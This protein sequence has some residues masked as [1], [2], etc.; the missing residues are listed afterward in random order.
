MNAHRE[1]AHSVGKWGY[2]TLNLHPSNLALASPQ[3]HQY[4]L[5]IFQTES[6][7]Y[8]QEIKR[9]LF[10]RNHN[11]LSPSGETG[12]PKNRPLT[13]RNILSEQFSLSTEITHLGFSF[14][15]QRAGSFGVN[16]RSN[17]YFETDFNDFA[18]EVLFQGDGFANYIDTVVR[19][20]MDNIENGKVNEKK[21]FELLEDSYLKIN[22][23]HEVNLGYARQVHHKGRHTVLGGVKLGY[24][25]GHADMALRFN[26]G[27]IRGYVS[28]IPYLRQDLGAIN[29]PDD[30]GSRSRTGHG[31]NF[32]IGGTYLYNSKLRLGLSLMDFGMIRWPVNPVMIKENLGDNLDLQNGLENAF[33]DLIE[34]GI[35][36]YRGRENNVEWLP[37]KIIMGA[38]Y[39]V[40]P[41]VTPYFDMIAPLNKSP[42]NFRGPVIGFGAE[43]NGWDKVFLRT[44]LS[45]SEVRVVMPTYLNVF[46]GKNNGY[47]VGIGTADML[48]FFLPRRDYFQFATGLFRF[49]F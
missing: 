32:G 49:H 40:H 7:I 35:F 42:K 16:V 33:N 43:V 26:E 30:I 5:G 22:I 2:Q 10:H 25:Y 14:H 17:V 4:S 46:V 15:T 23:T 24:I 18:N 21:V 41:R 31:F 3:Q 29:L 12:Y 6:I 11:G 20:I 28:R 44:G 45:F 34:D 1:Y 48:S 19:I 37:A 9:S 39:K 27:D 8:N 36:Y 13:I 47:E 38:S